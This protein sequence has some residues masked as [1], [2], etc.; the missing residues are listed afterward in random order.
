MS[1]SQPIVPSETERPNL[2]VE[3]LALAAPSILDHAPSA[4]R[5]AYEILDR[6]DDRH[7]A[8]H[9]GINE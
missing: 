4:T 6:A 3:S 7:Y 1:A 8:D 5:V 2:L 9:W